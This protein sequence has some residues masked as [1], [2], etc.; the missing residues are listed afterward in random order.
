MSTHG[1]CAA[2]AGHCAGHTALR[3]GSVV[4]RKPLQGRGTA[5]RRATHEPTIDLVHVP[6]HAGTS[7]CGLSESAA[8]LKCVD[9]G[10]RP[11]AWDLSMA[12]GHRVF[13]RGVAAAFSSGDEK[14]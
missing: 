5:H 2:R 3:G 13:S 14:P 9:G 6:R 1:P 8:L 7:T 4:C 12:G 11:T 10:R